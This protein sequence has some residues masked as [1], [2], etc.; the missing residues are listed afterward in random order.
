MK[1]I[2][3]VQDYEQKALTA[4][5]AV[6]DLSHP[7]SVKFPD[8][9]HYDAEAHVLVL[10]DLGD[11]PSLKAWLTPSSPV[12]TCARIGA[13]LGRFFA[14]VHGV[15][16]KNP[17]V[18]EQFAGNETARRLSALVYYD[19]LPRAAEAFGYRDGFIAEAAADAAREVMEAKEVLTLGDAWPG[20]VLVSGSVGAG[21]ED[22]KVE[23]YMIDL[24]LSKPGTAA[25]DIGQ[26]AAELYCMARFVD[27]ERGGLLLQNFLREYR[28]CGGQTSAAK[29]AIRVGAHFVVIGPM[30]WGERIGKTKLEE[31]VADGIKLISAGWREDVSALQETMLAPLL[32][33]SGI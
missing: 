10:Q 14:G 4:L 3:E 19:N 17:G 18:M 31:L 12:E 24:E 29:V 8:V 2:R 23:L 25:F 6:L 13:S 21:L 30:A 22:L 33:A 16:L 7:D 11:V 5:P 26:M 27:Q 20:N 28:A 9:L 1:L 15:R 32:D